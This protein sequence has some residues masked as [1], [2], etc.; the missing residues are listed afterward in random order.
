MLDNFIH[1]AELSTPIEVID[2]EENID[3]AIHHEVMQVPTII[4]IDDNNNAIKR[5]TG[6]LSPDQLKEFVEEN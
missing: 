3:A 5:H 2:A 4:L 6:L 1:E